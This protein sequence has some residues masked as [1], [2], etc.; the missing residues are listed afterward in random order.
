MGVERPKTLSNLAV[1]AV[2]MLAVLAIWLAGGSF[3]GAVGAVLRYWILV[4][5]FCIFFGLV[6]KDRFG[7]TG[8]V[9]A[10][11]LAA[12]GEIAIEVYVPGLITTVPD[13]G[14]CYDKQ[15]PHPC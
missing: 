2:S 9:L 15:G 11:V 7:M 1:T 13:D 10:F 5:L 12:V 8:L 14:T 3:I 4:F 6:L